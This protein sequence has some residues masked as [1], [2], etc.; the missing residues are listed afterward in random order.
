MSTRI[1]IA[2]LFVLSLVS[3]QAQ[4]QSWSF[5]ARKIAL[6][7]ESSDNL[8]TEIVDEQRPYRAIVLPFGL[9]QVLSNMSIFDPSSDEFDLI[10]AVEYSASPLHY[11]FG[12]GSTNTGQ[13]FSADI[14]NGRLTPDINAYRGF[15]PA[16]KLRAEGLSAS[17]WGKTFTVSQGTG[18][19]FHAI[20][21]G[22]GPYFSSK[23]IG[24]IDPELID[25]LASDNPVS[26][27][28]RRF[29][30]SDQTQ[31]QMALAVTGGYRGRLS[32][33]DAA[34]GD[35]DGLYVAFDYNYLHGFLLEDVN[36]NLR[37]DTG[38]NGLV[39]TVPGTVPISIERVSSRSGTG[40][41][42]DVGAT[43][44]ISNWEVGFGANGLGNHIDWSDAERTVFSL[45]NLVSGGSE[46]AESPTTIVGERRIELPVDYRGNITFSADVF[47]AVAEVGHGFQGTSF[48]GG[49][50]QRFPVFELRGGL[51]YVN[52]KWNPTGGIGFNLSQRLSLDVA[53]FGTTANVE[54]K[55]QLAIAASIRLN[56]MN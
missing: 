53:A 34:T 15:V 28:N 27:P 21:V 54:R 14:R 44:V 56:Q 23:S 46:F 31:G 22:A 47:T 6:G 55:R 12:R 51:R 33:G 11:T 45:S 30:L 5:D 39:T 42:I 19:S 38:A 37:I 4:A 7:G 48:H 17:S 40:M 8:A 25:V 49:V 13:Q 26:I 20:R 3:S 9:F 50:E 32:L 52:E 36:M 2:A 41:A 1:A 16:E 29:D 18:G 24:T 10:R 35:R 43:A